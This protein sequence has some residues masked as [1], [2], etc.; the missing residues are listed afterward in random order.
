MSANSLL[1]VCYPLILV[2]LCEWDMRWCFSTWFFGSYWSETRHFIGVSPIPYKQRSAIARLHSFLSLV[3][4]DCF[5]TSIIYSAV[6]FPW[7]EGSDDS[8]YALWLVEWLCGLLNVLGAMFWWLGWWVL[9]CAWEGLWES[10]LTTIEHVW[11]RVWEN[12]WVCHCLELLVVCY[13]WV[14]KMTTWCSSLAIFGESLPYLEVQ[15]Q[16]FSRQEERGQ[17]SL[18][19]HV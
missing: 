18:V 7:L 13:H 9:V 5:L 15:A 17:M 12:W 8:L 3:I 6:G 1:P 19:A 2:K 10:P 4:I 14:S 11:H 16:D